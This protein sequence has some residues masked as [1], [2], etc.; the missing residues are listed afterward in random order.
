MSYIPLLPIEIY[1]LLYKY[2]M[3]GVTFTKDRKLDKENK[4]N[5]SLAAKT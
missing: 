1:F 3:I 2:Y 5:Q 4:I